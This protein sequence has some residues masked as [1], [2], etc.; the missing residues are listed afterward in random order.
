ML[1]ACCL[2]ERQRPYRLGW[3]VR[4]SDL[5]GGLFVQG[6]CR[7]IQS[8]CHRLWVRVFDLLTATR[9]PPAEKAIGSPAKFAACFQATLRRRN[10]ALVQHFEFGP[11]R[12]PGNLLQ[13]LRY[14]H[15]TRRR[16]QA[17]GEGTRVKMALLSESY[18]KSDCPQGT[19]RREEGGTTAVRRRSDLGLDE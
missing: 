19:C 1:L 15:G 3:P 13:D 2:T 7:P 4:R 5:P 14:F 6:S 16:S 11:R 10:L 17:D 9:N 8:R 12:N 18:S